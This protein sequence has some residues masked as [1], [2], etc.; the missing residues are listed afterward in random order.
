MNFIKDIFSETATPVT[1]DGT[2]RHESFSPI[3]EGIYVKWYVDG[4]NYFHAVSEA[5]LSAQHEIYIED[6]WL[7]PELYLRRPPS[8]NEKFRLDR[9]LKAKA[10]QNV[11]IYVVLYKEVPQVLT[12]NSEHSQ[13]HLE[14]L[15]ENIHVL[16]HPD[17]GIDGTLFWAHHEKM[18]VVDRHL[19]FIGGL[20]L[21]FGRYD[22]GK[23]QVTDYSHLS[24]KLSVWPGQD[25]SNPRIK[26]FTDVENWAS[27]LIDKKITARMPW[28]DVSIGLIGKAARDVGRHFMQRWNFIKKHKAENKLKYP[29]LIPKSETQWERENS[30]AVKSFS[31][32]GKTVEVHPNRGPCNV[33]ILRSSAEWSLGLAETEHSIFNAYVDTIQNAKHFVYIEN[34]F[35][36]TAT[37]ASEDYPIKNLIGKAIV[38]RVTKAYKNKENFKIFVLMPLLP[39]FPAELETSGAATLRLIIHYQYNSICRGGHSIIEKIKEAICEHSGIDKS[40]E[41]KLDAIVENYI[42]FYGL[43]SHDRIDYLSVDEAKGKLIEER[44]AKSLIEAADS[45]PALAMS[46]MNLDPSGTFVTEELYIHTK[47]LI[48]DDRI[49]IIGSANLNDRSQNGDHDSEIAAIIEDREFIDSSF[50]GGKSGKFAT[51]LRR[52]IF[53][54]HLGI[55]FESDHESGTHPPPIGL[56]G[57]YR[58]CENDKFVENP[59]SDQFFQLWTNT[60]KTNTKIYSE[61]FACVPDDKVT[62]WE[63]YKKFVPDHAKIPIGHITESA[64]GN[65]SASEAKLKGIK[66]H[67]VTFPLKFMNKV[68]LSGSVVFDAITP[69]ELY[70]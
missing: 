17:H 6:W 22:T 69:M 33:Q 68:K 57:P 12:L 44:E 30:E 16:R 19:A 1:I 25:Y 3:R 43:R 54:E 32:S 7:S 56:I 4:K 14:G 31:Y 61:V 63:E 51:S 20:D 9:I 38:E 36:I 8:K 5:L 66:G 59:V 65:L 70:T 58:H 15:H 55:E 2:N 48:A 21:C 39:A 13:N 11:K 60:A 49:V 27:A 35:F 37:K 67:L 64:R 29:V 53:K 23:H 26:D 42:S 45:D 24:H 41:D 50:P 47:L 62:D 52:A 34:Q 40:E 28:H 10:E 18:V 46:I